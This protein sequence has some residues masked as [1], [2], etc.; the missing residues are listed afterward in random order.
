MI[1][2]ETLRLP[3][4]DPP[5]PS[6]CG[7]LYMLQATRLLGIDRADREQVHIMKLKCNLYKIDFEEKCH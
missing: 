5:N 1:I 4:V 3:C 2:P 7:E 6:V